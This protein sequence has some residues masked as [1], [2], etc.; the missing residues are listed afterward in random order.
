MGEAGNLIDGMGGEE[1]T[2][3]SAANWPTSNPY[4]TGSV[5]VGNNIV[6]LLG[7]NITGSITATTSIA[8]TTNV[9]STGSVVAGTSASAGTTVTAGTNVVAAGSVAC[10]GASVRGTL[11]NVTQIVATGSIADG[12]GTITSVGAGSPTTYGQS[13]QAGTTSIGAG[14]EGW[15]VFGTPFSS[16]P[17][18]VVANYYDGTIADVAVGSIGAGSAIL[19]GETASKEAN[20]IA[21][22]AK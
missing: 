2:T 8:A 6:G 16:A 3:G 17:T 21:V 22:G 9:V 20:W 5:T 4:I 18:S 7:A 13:V 14:S 10:S 12:D 15:A 1:V 11:T 19:Y